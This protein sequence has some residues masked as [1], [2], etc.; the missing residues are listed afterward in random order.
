[1]FAVGSCKESLLQNAFNWN[2]KNTQLRVINNE[3]FIKNFKKE[4]FPMKKL[5]TI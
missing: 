5:I 2:M 4:N 1:M 3:N